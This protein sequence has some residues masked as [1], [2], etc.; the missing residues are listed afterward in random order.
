MLLA[1]FFFNIE[2]KYLG[3]TFWSLHR[4]QRSFQYVIFPREEK[5]AFK[6]KFGVIY[7]TSRHHWKAQLEEEVKSLG[8]GKLG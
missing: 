1:F 4:H 6:A 2:K 7:V 8:R 5:D 3:H